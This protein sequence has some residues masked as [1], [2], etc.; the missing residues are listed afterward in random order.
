M[1]PTMI[2]T[3]I[4]TNQLLVSMIMTPMTA[5]VGMMKINAMTNKETKKHM[6]IV[7]APSAILITPFIHNNGILFL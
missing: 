3:G 1:I 4:E 5:A 7:P 6:T 2:P